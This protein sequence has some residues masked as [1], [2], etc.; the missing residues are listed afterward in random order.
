M[1]N[2]AYF[3]VVNK[4]YSR[5]ATLESSNPYYTITSTLSQEK[6]STHNPFRYSFP[7]NCW[8]SSTLLALEIAHSRGYGWIGHYPKLTGHTC[9]NKKWVA[10]PLTGVNP[11]EFEDKPNSKLYDLLELYCRILVLASY[12]YIHDLI[13]KRDQRVVWDGCICALYAEPC[14]ILSGTLLWM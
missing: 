9:I 6:K 1:V 11:R 4:L 13:C 2:L 7:L 3:L 5:A 10:L 14:D 12:R 8:F